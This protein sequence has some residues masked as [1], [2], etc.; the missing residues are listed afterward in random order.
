MTC[1]LKNSLS[2]CGADTRVCRVETRLDA[3]SGVMSVQ[4]QA[5]RRVSTRQAGGLRHIGQTVYLAVA[6]CSA[7]HGAAAI[8]DLVRTTDLPGIEGD[9][10][11]LAIDTAGQ[12]LFVAAEDNGTL[13]VI[14]LKTGKLERTVKGLKTPHSIL[15]LPEQSELYVT[16]GSKAVQVLDSNTFAVKKTIATTPGA[17]SIG[18]DS[19]HHLLYAVTGGKDVAMTRSALSEIDTKSARLVKELPIDA[20]HVEAMALEESGPRLFVNITDKNY[21]AV[22]DRGTGKIAAQWRIAEARQ[23]APIA[24]DEP[25]QRLFVV[26]RDPGILV[27]LDSKSGRSLA[28]FPTGAR[29]DEVIFDPTHHRVYVA[30]GEGKIYPYDEVDAD[31]FKPLPPIPSATGAKTALLSP[32]GSRLYV[33]VSPGDGKTGAKVLTY[34]VN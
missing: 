12:R 19:K 30:A 26:C 13:R 28:S 3:F 14:S 34:A 33:S 29:A 15:Y 20:A 16:D 17:D 18:V 6:L 7:Q 10:D 32:D 21:L 11:H 22:I 1:L 25:R 5:S 27:I 23:N 24:F 4:R 8:L 9:L 31:H 2:S